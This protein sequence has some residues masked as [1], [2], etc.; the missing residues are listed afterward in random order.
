MVEEFAHLKI[1]DHEHYTICYLSNPPS[2]T[3][4]AS[5]LSEIHQFLDEVEK[6]KR[7]KGL[8]LYWSR[9]GCIHKTL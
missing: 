2:H 1:E 6:K 8:G 5:G 3:L 4:T 9:K 7:L